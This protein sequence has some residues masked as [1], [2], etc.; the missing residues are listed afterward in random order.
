M[1][2]L[3]LSPEG[4]LLVSCKH[5][6]PANSGSPEAIALAASGSRPDTC[7]GCGGDGRDGPSCLCPIYG[8]DT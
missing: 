7:L 2:E 1:T 5:Y 8:E 3:H 6:E 4:K